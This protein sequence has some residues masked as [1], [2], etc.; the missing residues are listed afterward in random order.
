M[1]YF[2]ITTYNSICSTSSCP[3][4]RKRER[5][6]KYSWGHEPVP[7]STILLKGEPQRTFQ[8]QR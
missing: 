1:V 2:K 6:R 7:C 8:T 3:H 5:E 4:E